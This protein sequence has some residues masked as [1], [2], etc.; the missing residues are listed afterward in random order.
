[1]AENTENKQ[2]TEE[3]NGGRKIILYVCIA[4]IIA[5]FGVYFMFKGTCD[6]KLMTCGGSKELYFFIMTLAPQIGNSGIV[7]TL[8][9]W[10]GA[11]VLKKMLVDRK[12]TIER[13]IRE[14]KAQKERAEAIEAEVMEK[15]SH[16]E[17]EKIQIAESY[18]EAAK[19]ER[20]RIAE[21][22]QKTAERLKKDAEVSFELQANVAKRAFENEVMV[23]AIEKARTDITNRLK[24]DSALRDKLIEQSIASLEI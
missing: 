7:F 24:T 17:E 2:T 9:W 13:E 10:F 6:E 21:D 22:A 5:A 23:Q 14:S 18:R 4:I 12:A 3:N 11:P 8:L 20:E 16:L 19:A 1:M 15:T